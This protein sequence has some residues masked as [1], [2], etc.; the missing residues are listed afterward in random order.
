ME[1]VSE[2][3]EPVRSRRNRKYDEV[4]AVLR[5]EPGV[6]RKLVHVTE[7][8]ATVKWRQAGNRKGWQVSQRRTD[9]GWDVYGCVPET[10]GV[11]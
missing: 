8:R 9:T 1:A 7:R 10:E 11:R 4:D 5:A 2:I 6:W 3:P